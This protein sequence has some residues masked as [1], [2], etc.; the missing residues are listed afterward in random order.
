[1]K[2][3]VGALGWAGMA[4][5]A[6]FAR[7][8]EPAWPDPDWPRVAPAEAGMDEASL[9]EARDYALSGD[10][11]GCV[12]RGGRMVMEWGDGRQLFDLKS[13]TKAIGVTAL[14]LALMDGRAGLDDPAAKHHPS[15]GVPSE[16]NA[17]D[18][19]AGRC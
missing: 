18:G 1:M 17:R 2:R 3:A 15:F 10:G 6:M 4:A 9:A 11:A 7:G 13:S 16:E 5:A 14:G 12:L 8:A 19:R